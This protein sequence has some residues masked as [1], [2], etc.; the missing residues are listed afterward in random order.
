M[1]LITPTEILDN[2]YVSDLTATTLATGDQVT[3]AST[4]HLT[5]L[6][7]GGT[8]PVT[9]TINPVRKGEEGELAPIVIAVAAD[10]YAHFV[11]PSENYASDGKITF[12][13]TGTGTPA[14]LATY[15]N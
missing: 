7:T 2:S 15:T 8:N 14:C 3:Y 1:A 12:A 13:I 5:F 10:K 6:E 9:I 4:L 11:N